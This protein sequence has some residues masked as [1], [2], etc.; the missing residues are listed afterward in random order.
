MFPVFHFPLFEN[1]CARRK[2]RRLLPKLRYCCMETNTKTIES[3][4]QKPAH[5]VG[6]SDGEIFLTRTGEFTIIQYDAFEN[7][8]IMTSAASRASQDRAR[9]LCG[10]N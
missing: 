1:A 8:T 7:S 9:C 4:F 3:Y 10:E 2:K 5:A 6:S